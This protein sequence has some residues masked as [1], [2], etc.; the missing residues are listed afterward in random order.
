MVTLRV[1][2]VTLG[3]TVT[4][5]STAAKLHHPHFTEDKTK[6]RRWECSPLWLL[7]SGGFCLFPPPLTYS[8]S[9]FRPWH[10]HLLPREVFPG[11]QVRPQMAH[12]QHTTPLHVTRPAAT[13]EPSGW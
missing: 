9:S 13:K 6:P 8:P 11:L 5:V 12:S 3:R 1:T 7:L 2:C 4:L 10:E